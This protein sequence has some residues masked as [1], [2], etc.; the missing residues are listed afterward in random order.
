MASPVGH[1]LVGYLGYQIALRLG[2][3][4]GWLL[5]L[6]CVFAANVPDLD[7]VPGFFMNAPRQFHRAALS[8]SLGGAVVFMV[9]ASCV[10]YLRKRTYRWQHSLLYFSLYASHVVLDC[11][12]RGRGVPLFWPLSSTMYGISL[13][14]LPGLTLDYTS[15]ETF[16]ASLV[17]Y[18]NL[19]VIGIEIVMMLPFILFIKAMLTVRP[20]SR[21]FRRNSAKPCIQR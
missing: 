3:E 7:F 2:G 13:G 15:R 4:R 6:L 14:I 19:R 1:A 10:P 17:S 8:H 20:F 9:V 11:F 21:R 18:H 5:L 12:G 16:L